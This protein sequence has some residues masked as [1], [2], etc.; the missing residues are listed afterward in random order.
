MK[1]CM[2]RSLFAALV[3]SAATSV[4]STSATSA[5]LVGGVNSRPTGLLHNDKKNELAVLKGDALRA[6]AVGLAG[7][8]EVQ[9]V[10]MCLQRE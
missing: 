4:F 8:Q 6:A 10:S 5:G 9:K 3:V 1:S 2:G 7:G